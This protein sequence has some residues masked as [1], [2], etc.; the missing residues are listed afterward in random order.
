[1]IKKIFSLTVTFLLIATLLF[2][3]NPFNYPVFK[4]IDGNGDPLIG[5]KVYTYEPGTT[6]P[7]AA[8]TDAALTTPAT[9]PVILDSN[10]EAVFFFDGS[11]K[12]NLLTSADVQVSNFPVDNIVSYGT[13]SGYDIGTGAGQIPLNSDL[14]T[15]AV[16]NTG[17][18]P[19]DI[20]LNSDLGTA[21][22]EDALIGNV[23]MWPTAT[24][25][26]NY[27]ECDG[28]AVS[29]V[30]Y[31]NLFAVI[32]TL[33][34]VGDGSTTF[35]I[36]NYQGVFMRGFDNGAAVDPDAATRTDRGDTTGGDVVGSRQAENTA[37]H[38]HSINTVSAV[39][40]G[41]VAGFHYGTNAD[42]ADQ[43]TAST[44]GSETRP[45]NVSIMFCIRF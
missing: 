11:Y 40:G 2:A 27:L 9:N 12:V 15:A 32:S 38:V 19:G 29:R 13:A 31:A 22:T 39:T 41:A 43:D 16:K 24:P 17:T 42:V 10:G 26:T 14:G 7:K 5:G 23:V 33:Y 1:M 28:T 6:T 35:N 36:P 45:V 37:A 3:G 8:Y 25:P 21:A 20:P 4:G 44:V 34:G 30:T 18:A